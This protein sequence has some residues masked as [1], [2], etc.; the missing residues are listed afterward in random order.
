MALKSANQP[1]R[2][3][4]RIGINVGKNKRLDVGAWSGYLAAVL[5]LVAFAWYAR[6]IWAGATVTN[7]ISWW[8]WMGETFV[9][10]L[11][12]MD[13]TRDMPKWIAEATSLV[14]V[15]IV[16]IYLG[17]KALLGDA[18]MVFASVESID[19]VATVVALATFGFWLT[20]RK[21]WGAGPSIWVFQVT[22]LLVAFPLVRATFAD[23]SM[24]PFGPW[25]LWSLA[26]ILQA[27]CAWVRWD[28]YEPIIN[29]INYAVVHTVVA[30]I[31]LFGAAS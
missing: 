23:P 30:A 15:V 7:P 28:G 8:L 29:P 3:L 10:L 22:L 20:T 18:S 17:V 26:F 1:I 5:T 11:I 24:E 2:W 12:Y 4:Q 6:D 25:A 31:I 21:K 13:R 27:F 16:G 19:L 9:G 14:G